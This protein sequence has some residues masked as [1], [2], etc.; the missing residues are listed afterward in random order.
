MLIAAVFSMKKCANIVHAS[1]AHHF[2]NPS[3]PE[4]MQLLGVHLDEII[5]VATLI[6]DYWIPIGQNAYVNGK[7]SR[8]ATQHL[9]RIGAV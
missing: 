4:S 7:L 6:L 3:V 1:W 8:K 2:S 9:Q 5:A